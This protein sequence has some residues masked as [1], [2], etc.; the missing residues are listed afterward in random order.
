M[1]FPISACLLCPSFPFTAVCPT[2]HSDLNFMYVQCRHHCK[3]VPRS[4]GYQYWF[5][6]LEVILFC[7][8]GPGPL[9]YILMKASNQQ[10]PSFVASVQALSY[11]L[12]KASNQQRPSAF[13]HLSC[14][15]RETVWQYLDIQDSEGL[16]R[17]GLFS[18][19]V[20]HCLSL[21]CF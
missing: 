5:L 10:K 16:D 9:L 3:S 1:S 7:S 21:N 18:C 2:H 12:I 13:F 11:I 19:L 6:A 15:M 8:L 17:A 4:H 20:K 14:S